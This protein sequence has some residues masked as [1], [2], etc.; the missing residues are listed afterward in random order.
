MSVYYSPFDWVNERARVVLL[1]LTPG[2]TQMELA[3]RGAHAAIDE[4]KKADEICREA[5]LHGAFAGPLRANLLRMLD[6]IGLP[7][8]LDT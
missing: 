1:G 2:W 8:A 6:E 5:K 7:E 4:G 3:Y